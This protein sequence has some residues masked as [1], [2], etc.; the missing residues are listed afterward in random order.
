MFAGQGKVARPA[1]V[2]DIEAI[3]GQFGFEFGQHVPHGHA[4]V[5]VCACVRH[6]QRDRAGLRP[7]HD[8]R[9]AGQLDA[10]LAES[11]VGAAVHPDMALT[12]AAPR[13]HRTRIRE[14]AAR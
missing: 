3:A 9:H 13:T 6:G 10:F 5:H 1:G 7:G 2:E 12:P 14:A 8:L 11:H 4:T